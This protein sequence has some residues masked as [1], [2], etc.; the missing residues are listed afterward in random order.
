MLCLTLK[1]YTVSKRKSTRKFYQKF[2]IKQADKVIFSNFKSKITLQKLN[3][4]Y[5]FNYYFY[6]WHCTS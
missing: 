1:I 5:E 3:Y 2:R 4:F 6:V